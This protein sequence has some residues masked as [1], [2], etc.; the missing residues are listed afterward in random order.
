MHVCAYVYGNMPL[1]F[2]FVTIDKNVHLSVCLSVS[3]YPCVFK[4]ERVTVCACCMYVY[5]WSVCV[6][7]F[8]YIPGW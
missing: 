8:V 2:F 5:V 7:V 4:C 6:S 3:V 1:Y